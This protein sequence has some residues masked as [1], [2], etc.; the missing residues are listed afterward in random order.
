MLRYHIVRHLPAVK[1]AAAEKAFGATEGAKLRQLDTAKAAKLAPIF[2]EK[3]ADENPHFTL[4]GHSP[5]IRTAATMLLVT[6]GMANPATPVVEVPELY[7]TDASIEGIMAD[8]TAHNINI[9]KWSSE[10][11][12]ALD[13]LGKTGANGIRRVLAE[14]NVT[15]G[16][17]MFVGHGPLTV[18]IA[19][20]LAGNTAGAKEFCL[21]C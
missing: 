15:E 10:G 1:N 19:Y 9:S 14:K 2:R 7:W 6:V 16:D 17:A 20:H 11:L 4:L 8:F 3:L 21:K 13:T 12:A 18:A 5:T